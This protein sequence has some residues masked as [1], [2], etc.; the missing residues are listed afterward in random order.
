MGPGLTAFTGNECNLSFE[1]AHVCSPSLKYT[2]RKMRI[3]VFDQK[4]STPPRALRR[5]G[6]S[7][8]LSRADTAQ[9]LAV[10][11]ADGPAGLA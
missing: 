6:V 3:H 11:P 8:R 5:A 4:R 1:L 2:A 7:I 10:Q 9:F